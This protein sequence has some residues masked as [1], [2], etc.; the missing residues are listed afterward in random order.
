MTLLDNQEA[1]CKDSDY[2]FKLAF[3]QTVNDTTRMMVDF[4]A[5]C[6]VKWDCLL[7]AIDTDAYGIWGGTTRDFRDQMKKNGA[8]R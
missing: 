1:N 6:P 3:S 4:C 8:F 5:D 2:A 7:F